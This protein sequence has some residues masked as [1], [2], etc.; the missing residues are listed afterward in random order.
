MHIVLVCV[1]VRVCVHVHVRHCRTLLDLI[2]CL[3]HIFTYTFINHDGNP[4]ENTDSINDKCR[5]VAFFY[6]VRVCLH[7]SNLGKL[8]WWYNSGKSK[9]AFTHTS[10]RAI[11]D[12]TPLVYS[13]HRDIGRS[14]IVTFF[15]AI[16]RKKLCCGV[17]ISFYEYV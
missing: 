5:P 6:Q 14:L 10:T 16:H 15:S 1:C 12:A 3:C 11:G 4:L 2:I 13:S 9:N 7:Y 17:G 8:Y